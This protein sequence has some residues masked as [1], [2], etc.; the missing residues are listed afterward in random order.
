MTS[1]T[2]HYD[3][4]LAAHYTWMLGGDIVAVAREQARLLRELGVGPRA[5]GALAVDLGCGPGTQS[6]ALAELGCSPV[7]AVDTSRALLD[8]LSDLAGRTGYSSA[9]QP[10]RADIRAALTEHTRPSSVAAVVC[11]GDTLTHLPTREDVTALLRDAA[12]ALAADGQL[13][14][15]YR[16]LTSPLTGT[17]RFLPVRADD[18]RI[19]TCFLE[20]VDDDTVV[21]HDLIHTRSGSTWSQQV[22]SYPKLRIGTEWLTRSCHDAGLDVQHNATRPS[23]LHII[24]ATKGAQR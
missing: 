4:L 5:A 12:Q 21:V 11:M 3:R 7:L 10:V 24:T 9:I 2:E 20:Y 19:M 16:D 15:S 18:D 22:S 8:E 13:V 23:G 17:D 14:L 1:A 6:L